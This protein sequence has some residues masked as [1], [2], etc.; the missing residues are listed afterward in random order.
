M[1]VKRKPRLVITLALLMSAIG[2]SMMF[3]H[4]AQGAKVDRIRAYTYIRYLRFLYGAYVLAHFRISS[5][6]LGLI[7][8][9]M[10]YQYDLGYYKEWPNWL[11]KLPKTA[12]VIANSV[13]ASLIILCLYRSAVHSIPFW[14]EFIRIALPHS[15]VTLRAVWVAINISLML[16]IITDWNTESLAKFFRWQLWKPLSRLSF[17]M[18]L[19]GFDVMLMLMHVSVSLHTS[20]RSQFWIRFGATLSYTMI[21]STFVHVIFEIPLNKMAKDLLRLVFGGTNEV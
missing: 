18:H 13:L 5:P 21:L 15:Q 11:K 2:S 19:V 20:D 12:A 17:A 14:T 16:R 9:Y 4:L 1:L 6:L 8:G 3:N 10:L 7:G